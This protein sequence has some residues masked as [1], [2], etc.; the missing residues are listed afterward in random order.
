MTDIELIDERQIAR[1]DDSR[2][3]DLLLREADVLANAT[4]IVPA[5]Y[6][7]RPAE[8]VAAGLFGRAFGWDIMTSVRNI[9]VIDG[10]VS[11]RPEAML[12]LVRRDGHSVQFE[13]ADGIA[14]ATG[15]RADNGD[16]HVATFSL[17]DA[18]AAG[19]AGKKN[20][21]QYEDAML[22]WRAV[23]KLCRFLFSDV[24]L[25]AGY[26]PEELGAEVSP[27]GEPIEVDYLVPSSSAKTK[28]ID[29]FGKDLAVEL[30]GDRKNQS[31]YA[32]QLHELEEHGRSI[33]VSNNDSNQTTQED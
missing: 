6:R 24:V 22:T 25:G 32:S 17:D 7:K 20:W 13:V 26:V 9:Y 14:T 11:M 15:V 31:I 12:G 10:T 21:K 3:F 4:N 5:N 19:L 8:I 27:D 1:A 16:K 18:Q 2:Y 29:Q 23:S 28:L 33:L 30:W